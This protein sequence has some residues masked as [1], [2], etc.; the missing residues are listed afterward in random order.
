MNLPELDLY[1]LRLIRLISEHG[2]ITAATG[3]SG[4]SQSALTRHIQK[5]ENQLGFKVFDRTT[6]KVELTRAG[7]ILL[8]ETEAMPNILSAALRKVREEC[9]GADQKITI[10]VSSALAVA[11]IP[12]IFRTR[13]NAESPTPTLQ[14]KQA[15][16]EEVEAQIESAKLDLGIVVEVSGKTENMKVTHTMNDQFCAVIASGSCGPSS[17]GEFSS[18]AENQ[19]WILPPAG[20]R[21][22]NVIDQWAKAVQIALTSEIELENFDLMNQ[23]VA[24]ELGAAFV[25]RRSLSGLARRHKITKVDLPKKLTRRLIVVAPQFSEVPTHVTEFVEGIL[26]S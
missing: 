10:G 4:L 5:V 2:G 11:H 6:R 13:K 22:R 7:A 26:F 19:K 24:L 8:K 9:L 12:G 16:D 21:T 1:S 15:S 3:E 23:F 20:S 14:I 17:P 18:W 25:P